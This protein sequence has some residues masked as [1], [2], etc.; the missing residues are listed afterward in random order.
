MPTHI[1][2]TGVYLGL[3]TINLVPFLP[4]HTNT[5]FELTT[6]SLD[7]SWS[8]ELNL[9]ALFLFIIYLILNFGTL[10]EIYLDY[11][12]IRGKF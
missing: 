2:L 6:G 5:F 3:A 12:E 8:P 9:F 11:K 10:V 4:F 7:I 1:I